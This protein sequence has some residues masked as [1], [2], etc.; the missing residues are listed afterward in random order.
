MK[1]LTDALTE[2]DTAV[3]LLEDTVAS[4][5]AAR[6]RSAAPRPAKGDDMSSLF[7]DGQLTSVKQRLDDAIERLENAL[8]TTD[9]AR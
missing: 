5:L 6:K 8:E 9:G 4:Q 1:R 3:D 7:S 2:L